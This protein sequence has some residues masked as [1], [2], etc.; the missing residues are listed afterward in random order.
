ML[1]FLPVH[2]IEHKGILK[3]SIKILNENVI[4]TSVLL[5]SVDY[6]YG[7][8]LSVG[9]QRYAFVHYQNELMKILN[10]LFPRVEIK[11]TN[12]SFT[13]ARFCRNAT[14]ALY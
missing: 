7:G 9:T 8:I 3:H 10:I 14:T 12:I 13:A 6:I 2:C 1:L 11:P 5:F 4:K